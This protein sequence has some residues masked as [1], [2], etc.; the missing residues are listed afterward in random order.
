MKYTLLLFIFIIGFSAGSNAQTSISGSISSDATWTFSASPYIVT[1]DVFV[2]QGVTLSID[3]GVTI[4]FLNN[5]TLEVDGNIV[6]VG[7]SDSIILFTADTS[8]ISE[9]WWSGIFISSTAEPFNSTTLDGCQFK[10]V[11]FEYAGTPNYF[12]DVSG[13]RFTMFTQVSV[14]ITKC[15]V[16]YCFGKIETAGTSA[17]TNS[18]FKY[19]V[20]DTT[21]GTLIK[22]GSN[23]VI[24][25]NIFYKNIVSNPDGIVSASKNVKV[26]EN[27]FVQNK[28]IDFGAL[29][30]SDSSEVYKNIFSDNSNMSIGVE[31]GLCYNNTIV[32]NQVFGAAVTLLNASP[33][34]FNNNILRNYVDSNSTDDELKTSTGSASADVENNWWGTDDNSAIESEI[35]DESDDAS[36]CSADFAPFLTSPDIDAP[37]VPPTNVFK[38]Q[39]LNGDVEVRWSKNL[40][41]DLEGYRI[42][43]NGFNGY[44]FSNYIDVG[45]DTV[46][47]LTTVSIDDTLAVTAIDHDANGNSDQLKSRESWFTYAELDTTSI[48]SGINSLPVQTSFKIYP[49]PSTEFFVLKSSQA[50]PENS[51][52]A[53]YNVLGQQVKSI[54]VHGGNSAEVYVSDFPSGMYEVK[55]M[56][57]GDCISR[58]KIVIQK[59]Y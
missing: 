58:N 50:F 42:Y 34:F 7:K 10:Y 26:Y 2:D 37:L 41:S 16:Q 18:V 32:R 52:I 43:F 27:A 6:A 19:N 45:L 59:T 39:L 36:L 46:H 9:P 23:S 30:I 57:N 55:V 53:I 35:T 22:L 48:A 29:V 13:P 12:A 5:K 3:P 38:K 21:A 56:N 17:V 24:S 15:T 40:E 20:A 44:S 8:G 33:Q 28:F 54:F 14:G 4:K 11:N 1:G 31:Q 49:N 25:Q 47:E 51:L